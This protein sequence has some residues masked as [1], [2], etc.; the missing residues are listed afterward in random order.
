MFDFIS[1]WFNHGWSYACKSSRFED[2]VEDFEDW[3]V[4]VSKDEEGTPSVF[5]IKGDD[6]HSIDA[7]NDDLLHFSK[8]YIERYDEN[9]DGQIS[10]DEFVKKEVEQTLENTDEDELDEEALALA[11]ESLKTVFDNLNIDKDSSKDKLD[12]REIM[13]YVFSMDSMNDDFTADGSITQEEYIGMTMVLASNQTQK[14]VQAYL[15]SNYDAFF[16]DYK[17]D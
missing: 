16:K 7:F 6:T 10:M 15:K 14:T 2:K 13:N 3:T 9:G 8:E 12:V 4:N 5:Q 17:T 11:K 1:N